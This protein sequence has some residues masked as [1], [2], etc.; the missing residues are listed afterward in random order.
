MSY[1]GWFFLGVGLFISSIILANVYESSRKR[2]NKRNPYGDWDP[3]SLVCMWVC[4]VS[5]VVLMLVFGIRMITLHY[6]RV[7]CESYG[8][9]THQ[10]V[11]FVTLPAWSTACLVRVKSGKWIPNDQIGNYNQ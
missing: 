4:I 10:V 3:L 6:N 11:R 1:W 5:G 2:R 8:R 9:K 7:G